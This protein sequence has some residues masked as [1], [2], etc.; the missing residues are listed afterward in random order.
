MTHSGESVR[1]GSTK[2]ERK[3]QLEAKAL[4]VLCLKCGAPPGE[5]CVTNGLGEPA[6]SM[7]RVRI[8]HASYKPV[9]R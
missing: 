6:A 8:R 3:R 4:G 5:I 2:K 1:E 9:P 7:H